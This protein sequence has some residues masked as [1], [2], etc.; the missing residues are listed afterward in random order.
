MSF[1]AR[2]IRIRVLHAIRLTTLHLLPYYCVN[3][4]FS[5]TRKHVSSSP[6]KR[7][8]II[9]CIGMCM[10]IN[11]GHYLRILSNN[12]AP[13]LSRWCGSSLSLYGTNIRLA[14]TKGKH[15]F[16]TLLLSLPKETSAGQRI[17]CS[18]LYSP[19]QASG[20]L[21]M[22]RKRH[23]TTQCIKHY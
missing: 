6:I 15:P 13:G 2:S 16:L 23:R 5:L 7:K 11:V 21:V 17:C 14:V 10:T 22:S 19:S 18:E 9:T 12:Q 3:Q 8:E 4:D 20:G 1:H